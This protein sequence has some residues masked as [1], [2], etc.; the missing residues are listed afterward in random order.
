MIPD[1]VDLQWIARHLVEFREETRTAIADLRR[2]M[3]MTIRIVTR[4]DHTVNALR[5]DI[6]TLWLSHG[7]LRR[8]LENLERR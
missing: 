7:D 5:E 1:N 3:D 4:L 8:R 6:Q 2:D